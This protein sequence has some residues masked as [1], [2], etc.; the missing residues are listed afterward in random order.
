MRESVIA[1]DDVFDRRRWPIDTRPIAPSVR[2]R[3]GCA[4]RLQSNRTVE[5]ADGVSAQIAD[6]HCRGRRRMP[7]GAP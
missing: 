5:L 7:G 6:S 3:A 2:R 4:L 1:S